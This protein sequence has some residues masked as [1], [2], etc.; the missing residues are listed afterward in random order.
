MLLFEAHPAISSRAAIHAA[1]ALTR[2]IRSVVTADR[3]LDGI[4]GLRRIDPSDVATVE[5]LVDRG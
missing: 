1:T 4:P 5:A 2:G 3:H